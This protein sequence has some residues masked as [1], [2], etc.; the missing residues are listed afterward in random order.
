M[1]FAAKE[2]LTDYDELIGK[3]QA[4][5][6]NSGLSRSTA[7]FLAEGIYTAVTDGKS[8]L[9]YLIGPDAEQVYGMR[10]QVGDDAFVAGI[11]ERMLS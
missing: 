3:F 2:G 5:Q 9:R 8:Q 1:V 4:N 6:A 7:E 11:K 10:Q